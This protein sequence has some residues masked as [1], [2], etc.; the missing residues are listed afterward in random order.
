MI[1]IYTDAACNGK[2][3]KMTSSCVVI[4]DGVFVG[5]KDFKH[6]EDLNTLYAEVWGAVNAI[7]FAIAACED[8]S[9]HEITL[10]TDSLGCLD[11]TKYTHENSVEQYK[12]DT[13][14]QKLLKEYSIKT[15][16]VRGHSNAHNPNKIVDKFASRALRQ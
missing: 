13:Q 4:K 1:Y 12:L 16:L 14:F 3:R 6:E 5:M 11:S 10:F 8:Y 9:S 2:K 7:E 15:Q